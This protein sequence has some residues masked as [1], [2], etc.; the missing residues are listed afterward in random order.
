MNDLLVEQVAECIYEQMWE[1]VGDG[2]DF[3]SLESQVK[4]AY[5]EMAI[6]VLAVVEEFDDMIVDEY[7]EEDDW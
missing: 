1:N 6:A 3:E 5:T 4:N 7:D 2:K